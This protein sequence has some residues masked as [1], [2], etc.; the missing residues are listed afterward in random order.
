MLDRKSILDPHER[1][2]LEVKLCKGG[3]PKSIWSTYSSFGGTIVLGI[4]EDKASGRFIPVGVVN[5]QSCFQTYPALS[6]AISFTV[7]NTKVKPS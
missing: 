1:A 7:L 3:L 4:Q 6:T 2:N 5:P